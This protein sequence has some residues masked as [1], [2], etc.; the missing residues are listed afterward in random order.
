[1]RA[2]LPSTSILR[3]ATIQALRPRQRPTT[4]QTTLHT[5]SCST[6]TMMMVCR[7]KRPL[8]RKAAPKS[9]PS[10]SLTITRCHRSKISLER[11]S[12]SSSAQTRQVL[13]CS[14]LLGFLGATSP[15]THTFR[16]RSRRYRTLHQDQTQKRF[17]IGLVC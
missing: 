4:T 13:I 3:R 10:T 12:T 14:I 15:H 1:M 6:R 8:P 7:Q 5:H 16:S 9:S 2:S 17:T 11:G